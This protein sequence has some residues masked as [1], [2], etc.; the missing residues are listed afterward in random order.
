M[1]K[2]LASTWPLART[3]GRDRWHK[4]SLY[5]QKANNFISPGQTLTRILKR[6]SS[7]LITKLCSHMHYFSMTCS[8]LAGFPVGFKA[9][10][11]DSVMTV[12]S[13]FL[14]IMKKNPV[15]VRTP[16]TD[17]IIHFMAPIMLTIRKRSRILSTY[18]WWSSMFWNEIN[19]LFN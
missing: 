6:M 17:S 12:W 3:V 5:F 8:I 1:V 4:G 10:G 13:F 18:S 11:G 16:P 19:H 15:A 2:R 9:M 7:G 14:R